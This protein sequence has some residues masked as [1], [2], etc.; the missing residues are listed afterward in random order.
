MLLKSK[1]VIAIISSI[2][3]LAIIFT[4]V[5]LINRKI[6][7]AEAPITKETESALINQ[8]ESETTVFKAIQQTAEETTDE[9]AAN[10]EWYEEEYKEIN[11][12]QICIVLEDLN[13]LI[14]ELKGE[15][16]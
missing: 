12:V 15:K 13:N 1:K 9:T 3:V 7:P 14:S 11:D 5:F 16:S 10:T 2:L 6:K 8:A 4:T